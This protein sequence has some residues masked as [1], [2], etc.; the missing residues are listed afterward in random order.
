MIVPSKIPCKVG[1]N[2]TEIVQEVPFASVAGQFEVS[3]KNAGDD[4]MLAM[5]KEPVPVLV[6]YHRHR[7]T[8]R[9]Y[10]TGSEIETL[11]RQRRLSGGNSKALQR[12]H[13]GLRNIVGDHDQLACAQARVGGI[14]RYLQVSAAEKGRKCARA[15]VLSKGK[16]SA[17]HRYAGYGDGG[18]A[19]VA[20]TQSHISDGLLASWLLP[21]VERR[22]LDGQDS[23]RGS[24]DWNQLWRSR[25]NA[26]FAAYLALF[27]AASA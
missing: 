3:G 2:L 7:I 5:P 11:G 10:R 13:V 17:L 25:W 9:S 16:V 18:V 1:A 14:E 6:I 23:L 19:R 15:A 20:V 21:K 12:Y 27:P 24:N 8:L 22:G 26:E 4:V